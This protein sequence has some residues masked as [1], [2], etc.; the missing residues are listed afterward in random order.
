MAD[1][2][3]WAWL[4]WT[5]TGWSCDCDDGVTRKWYTGTFIR[6]ESPTGWDQC[7]VMFL[8]QRPVVALRQICQSGKL[9][10]EFADVEVN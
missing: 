2:S 4:R 10:T 8:A 5:R 6:N 3:T 9:P 7:E 1:T